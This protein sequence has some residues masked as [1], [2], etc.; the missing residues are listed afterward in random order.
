MLKYWVN[1]K[2]YRCR[3]IRSGPPFYWWNLKPDVVL[4]QTPV[5]TCIESRQLLQTKMITN[6]D[7]YY[8]QRW[9]QL[10]PIAYQANGRITTAQPMVVGSSRQRL[11]F[12]SNCG[13]PWLR[14][15]VC[16]YFGAILCSQRRCSTRHQK[17]LSTRRSPPGWP[18]EFVKK[19]PKL[20]PNPFLSKWIHILN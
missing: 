2:K 16:L 6:K 10:H 15:P 14:L 1:F 7:D 4:E 8:K 9:L 11:L 18:D 19:S 17:R 5:H 3:F 13:Y 20:L 12:S